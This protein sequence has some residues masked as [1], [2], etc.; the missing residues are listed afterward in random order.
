MFS[1]LFAQGR[2]V[3]KRAYGVNGRTV[4]RKFF[5]LQFDML[6]DAKMIL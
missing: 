2:S 3:E 6:W 5:L 1:T 4:R